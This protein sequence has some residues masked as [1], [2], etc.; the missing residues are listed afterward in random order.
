MN[1]QEEILVELDGNRPNINYAGQEH[2]MQ[3]T[4]NSEGKQQWPVAGEVVNKQLDISAASDDLMLLAQKGAADTEN[5]ECEGVEK[6]DEKSN[7]NA[8]S[9]GNQPLMDCTNELMMQLNQE[10]TQDTLKSKGQWKRKARLKGQGEHQQ[11]SCLQSEIGTSQGKR[12]L[13]HEESI[14]MPLKKQVVEAGWLIGEKENVATL[15]EVE[16]T[17]RKW[18]QHYK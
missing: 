8:A 14:H 16:E 2:S 18:S 9:S 12:K 4:K 15:S 11:Q 7:V 3:G 6:C 1:N 10:V 13:T 5:M 17:T